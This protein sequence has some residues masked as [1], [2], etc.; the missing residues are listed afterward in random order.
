MKG[1]RALG[2]ITLSLSLSS[3]AQAV[4]RGLWAWSKVDNYYYLYLKVRYGVLRKG[5]G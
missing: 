2:A 1:V 3:T 4:Q 5:S